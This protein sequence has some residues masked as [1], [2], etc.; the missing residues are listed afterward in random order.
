MKLYASPGACS[1]APHIALKELELEHELEL[2]NLFKGDTMSP[3]H[4]QRNPLGMVPVLQLENGKFLTE[5]SVILTYLAD[6][7]P[8]VGLIPAPGQWERYRM[9]QL[10]SLI[11]TEFHKSFLPFF[12]GQ[13]M[14]SDS[15]SREELVEFFRRR[16]EARWAATS[17]FLGSQDWLQGGAFSVADIYLYVMASWWKFLKLS[18]EKWPNLEAWYERVKARPA[19][20]AAHAAE[21]VKK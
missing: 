20:Q 4:T 7:K 6:L 11:A 14:V 18:L 8:E 1:L 15:Q 3:E 5:C 13:K 16:V 9:Q 21:K 2:L 19:V 10:L 17:E 12:Y